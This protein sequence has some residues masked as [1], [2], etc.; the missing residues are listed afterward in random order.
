MTSHDD[1]SRRTAEIL[2]DGAVWVEAPD[3]LDR[4]MREIDAPPTPRIRRWWIAVPAAVIAVV[5]AVGIFNGMQPEDYDFTMRGTDLAP[6][7]HAAVRIVETPAGI[8]LRLEMEGLDPALPGTYYQGW[9]VSG[10]RAVS[11]G[12]FHMRG[13]DGTV[14]FWSGVDLDRYDEVVITLQGE[15]GGPERSD[16]V[17]MTGRA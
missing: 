14:A 17:V 3:M 7:A 6:N 11:V 12:T 15:D 2:S 10:E 1:R 13:G 9:V 5:A 8:I 16:V 4:I